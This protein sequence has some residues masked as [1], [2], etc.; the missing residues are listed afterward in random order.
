MMLNYDLH[1]LE[2]AKAN[3]MKVYEYNYTASSQ[4]TKRCETIIKKIDE[5]IAIAEKNIAERNNKN[6]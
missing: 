6:K 5:L 2:I 3:I 1:C 4:E